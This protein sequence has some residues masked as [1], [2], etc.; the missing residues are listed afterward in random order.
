MTTQIKPVRGKVARV[1]NEREVAINRGLSDGVEVGMKFKILNPETQEVRDPD[2]GESLGY[3]ERAK[4]PVRVTEI[5]DK[6]AVA[7]TFRFRHVNVGGNG[8]GIGVFTPP[9]WE[10]RYETLRENGAKPKTKDGAEF[11]KQVSIGDIVVQIIE[12][13]SDDNTRKPARLSPAP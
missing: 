11:S 8:I 2:T 10:K 1:L 4:I 5:Q 7:T 3:V 12:A 6:F 13:E 9:K